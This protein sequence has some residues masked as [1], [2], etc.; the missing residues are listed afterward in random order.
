ME[1]LA[2]PIAAI[3][4]GTSNWASTDTARSGDV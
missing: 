3:V 1:T 4:V 2:L